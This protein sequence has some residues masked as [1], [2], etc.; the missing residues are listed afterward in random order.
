MDQKNVNN[1]PKELFKPLVRKEDTSEKISRPSR[2][3]GQ[4]ARRTLFKNI[5][6]MIS[7]VVLILIIIMSIIGPFMNKYGSNDQNLDHAKNAASCP[8]I[9]ESILVRF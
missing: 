1:L 8:W 2:T 7:L 9:R 6:A 5:P 4:N 3:F